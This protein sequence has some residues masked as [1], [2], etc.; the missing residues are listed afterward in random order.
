MKK[1]IVILLIAFVW[2]SCKSDKQTPDIS[3]IT[4]KTSVQRFD[5][6]FFSIDTLQ[7]NNNLA[8]LQQK[9]PAFLQ[10]F[11]ENIAGV[12]AP[13]ELKTFYRIYRPVFDSSQKTY[14]NFNPIKEQIEEAFRYT[15]YYFPQYKTPS[16]LITVIG[17]MDS[18]TDLA[19]M[20]NGD[21]TP[22]FLGPDLAGISLQFYLGKDFSFYQDEYFVNNIA[23]LYRSRRFSKEYIVADVMKLVVDDMYPDKSNTRPLVEQMIEKGKHWWL[24]DKVM[25]DA[26]DSVKTGFTKAQLDWCKENEGLNWT[27][28]VRNETLYSIDPATIQT[29]IG[30]SPFT[31]ALSQES[32]PGNIGSWFGRQIVTKYVDS[33]P[34]MK[35]DEVMKMPAMKI[36]EEAKYKPK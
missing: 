32:S 27:Y 9:Y 33:H 13:E 1:A 16:Q 14:K 19:R 31:S 29:Y 12:N 3:K 6:D 35:P 34:G 20:D 26:P 22:I 15:K 4:A 11:L 17:R 5:Q 21:Y 10:V 30:E 7:L 2:V 36:L 25:P 24:L 23:P 8:T 18:R 28:I